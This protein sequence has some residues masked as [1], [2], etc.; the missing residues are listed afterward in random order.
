MVEHRD[1]SRCL[2]RTRC[3]Y[4]YVFDTPVPDDAPRVCGEYRGA[5]SFVLLPPLGEFIYQS[6]ETLTAAP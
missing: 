1:C 3:A 2:L 5:A 4:P 6:D